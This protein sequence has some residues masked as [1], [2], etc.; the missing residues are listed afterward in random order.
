ML[1]SS[2]NSLREMDLAWVQGLRPLVTNSEATAKRPVTIK[3][4]AGISG[5]VRLVGLVG[6]Y[7][8][9]NLGASILTAR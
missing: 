5:E 9:A 6:A 2:L 7:L 1:P 3:S 8:I 4:P